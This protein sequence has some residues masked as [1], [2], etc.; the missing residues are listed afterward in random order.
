MRHSDIRMTTQTYLDEQLLPLQE[1]ITGLPRLFDAGS[2]SHMGSQN[3]VSDGHSSSCADTEAADLE[4]PNHSMN[5]GESLEMAG[6]GSE[7]Q[8]ERVKGIEPS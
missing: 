7:G 8:M 2:G 1:S 3:S 6:C 4:A 5:T